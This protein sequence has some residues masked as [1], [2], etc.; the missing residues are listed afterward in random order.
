MEERIDPEMALV[1]DWRL[2]Q[3]WRSGASTDQELLELCESRWIRGEAIAGAMNGAIRPLP[4]ILNIAFRPGHKL[5]Q[6]SKPVR[7]RR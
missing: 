5:L 2:E 1:V 6:F 3:S 7:E 4:V